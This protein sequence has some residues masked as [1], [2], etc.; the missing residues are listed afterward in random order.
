VTA[1]LAGWLLSGWLAGCW[2]AGWLTPAACGSA[3]CG[4]V[5]LAVLAAVWL[6][7]WFGAVRFA[8]LVWLAGC[9]LLAGWLAGWL[10]G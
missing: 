8:V 7:V 5:W 2:L 4:S 6:L 9:C 10:A 1:G 3:R